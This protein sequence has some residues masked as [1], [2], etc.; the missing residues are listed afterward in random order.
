MGMLNLASLAFGMIALLLPLTSLKKQKEQ[1]A[2][3]TIRYSFISMTACAFALLC[4]ILYA[5]HLVTLQDWS[6]LLD[7][8]PTVATVSMLLLTATLVLNAGIYFLRV[9][10][11]KREHSPQN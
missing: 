8:I 3:V 9:Y 11:N 10:Q 1:K 5:S 6:A 2:I 4:Q 7:T